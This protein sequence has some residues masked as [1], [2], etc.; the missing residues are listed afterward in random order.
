MEFGLCLGSNLGDRL[1]HLQAARASILAL[2]GVD[3]LAQSPV[4]DTEP[5]GVR[6]EYA[7]LTFLNA[8]LIVAAPPDPDALGG[9]LRAIEDALGRRRTDDR[10]APRPIDIDV[11]YAG[12][13]VQEDPALVLPHERW[14]RRRFVVQPLCDVRPDL[15]L[16]GEERTVREVLLALPPRPAVVVW[17]ATW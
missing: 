8:V 16:P 4:Y 13:V 7:A 9:R 1:A 14:S 17:T 3:L 2:P 5:V 15:R 12:S 11:I 10:Y 6:A